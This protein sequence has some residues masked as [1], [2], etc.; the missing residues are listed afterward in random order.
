S[1]PGL[2]STDQIVYSRDTIGLFYWE[3]LVLFKIPNT[4]SFSKM[5]VNKEGDILSEELLK[6]EKQFKYFIYK[7]GDSTGTLYDLIKSNNGTMLPVDS[8]LKK[9]AIMNFSSFFD[10]TRHN[11]SLIIWERQGQI[12][13]EKYIPKI[14]YDASYNDSTILFYKD[15]FGEMDFSLSKELDSIK[16]MK[17]CEV[18]F[19][20]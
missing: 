16:Q 10:A 12:L 11:D 6:I 9:K 5:I 20:Y 4:H 18:R 2:D 17:L 8:F 15:R 1:L 7:K 19:V 3:D 14:K 13:I